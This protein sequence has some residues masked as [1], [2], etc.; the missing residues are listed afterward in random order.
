MPDKHKSSKGANVTENGVSEK[1]ESG[2]S[3]QS[4]GLRNLPRRYGVSPSVMWALLF[5][6]LIGAWM[7]TGEIKGGSALKTE[8]PSLAEKASKKTSEETRFKVRTATFR[9][10]QY[11]EK[12]VIR[13]RTLSETQVDLKAETAGQ[14]IRLSAE[15][16]DFVKKDA[17]LCE[18]EDG[19]REAALLEAKA[20]VAQY[21]GDYLAAKTLEKRGH[22]AGLKVLESRAL[23]D[24]A[25]AA[26]KRAELDS[27]R[28]K[29]NAAFDG[30]VDELPS[31]VGSFLPIGGTCAR[32]V[33]LDPLIVAGAVRE[34]DVGKI[35]A[36]MKGVAHLVTGH[37]AEGEIRFISATAENETRTFRIDLSI[38]NS[39]G[40]LKSGVTAD[41]EIP[42][43]P[44]NAIQIPPSILT[45]NDEGKVGLR[46]VNSQQQVEFWPVNIL[47]EEAAGIWIEALPNSAHIITVGQDFVK[48]GQ[49]VDQVADDKFNEKPGS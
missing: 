11:P 49:K 27:E 5:T 43:E 41:I 19:G 45:L 35:K 46:I 12:L 40:K 21:E 18:L 44:R 16:G 26:L 24:R 13:G 37:S 48:A 32:L 3:Q 29:I 42:L 33:A 6:I 7:L 30:F 34:R 38:P 36:G 15:K 22:T 9:P 25:K 2:A 17:P 47:S 28:T 23:L 10:K 14:I 1:A 4:G 8:A 31:K 39:D 20:L